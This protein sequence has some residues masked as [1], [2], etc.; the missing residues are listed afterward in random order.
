VQ[1]EVGGGVVGVGRGRGEDD[2]AGGRGE[3]RGV[4]VHEEV[5][6][7]DDDLGAVVGGDEVRA[8]GGEGAHDV[9]EWKGLA[10]EVTLLGRCVHDG[11]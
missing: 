3:A 9:D 4:R 11:L 5:L 6:G 2:E 8:G 10:K 7:G 1:R